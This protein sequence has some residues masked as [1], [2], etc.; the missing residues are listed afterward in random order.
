MSAIGGPVLEWYTKLAKP[1]LEKW[2]PERLPGLDEE[3]Q[4]LE[5]L[6]KAWTRRFQVCFLGNSGVGKSTLINALVDD[7]MPVLPQGGVG[8]LTALATRVGHSAEPYF[9]ATYHTGQKLNRIL[10]ILERQ[11]DLEAGAKGIVEPEVS[12]ADVPLD[13]EDRVE[14]LS[15]VPEPTDPAAD[16]LLTKIEAYKRVASLLIGGTQFDAHSRNLLF[17]TTGLRRALGLP[18]RAEVTFEPAEEARL[19]GL[20]AALER[21]KKGETVRVALDRNQAA[22]FQRLQEHAAGFLAPLI[23][24]IQVGWTGEVLEA[25]LQLVDLPGLGVA[26]DEYRQVTLREIREAKAVVLVVDRSGVTEASADLLRTTGFLNSLL[27]DTGNEDAEPVVLVVAVVKLDLTADDEKKQAKL[28][29]KEPHRRWL[30]YFDDVCHRAESLI[31]GQVRDELQKIL[32]T[33]SQTHRDEKEA[34]TERILSNLRIVP[35]SA[36]EHVRYYAGDDDD[37]ARIT[38]PAQSRIPAFRS[39]LAEAANSRNQRIASALSSHARSLASRITRGVEVIKEQWEETD[40]ADSEGERLREELD[41]FLAPRRKRMA[42]TR[43][44][45]REFLR[46]TMKEKIRTAV[47]EATNEARKDIGKYL[48]SLRKY[49][50]STL[51]AA[52]RRGG[53]FDGARTVDLPGE[54][55]LKFEE[56]LAIVWSKELLAPLRKRTS[57]LGE[58]YSRAVEE[59]ARWAQDQGARVNAKLIEALS[60]EVKEQTRQFSTVGRELVNELREKVKVELAEAIE[61]RVRKRCLKFVEDKQAEGPGVLSRMLTFFAGD[62]TDVVVDAAAKVAMRVLERNYSEVEA[63]IQE[64]LKQH[65]DPLEEAA[66]QIVER[67]EDSV[68]RRDRKVRKEVLEAAASVLEMA[69]VFEGEA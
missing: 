63:E 64:L 54:F 41:E 47:L 22:F 27:H 39:M 28:L 50:W 37:R 69:P 9:E 14:A 21:A 53:Y 5:R 57:E 65:P 10:F 30:D 7:R 34:M 17:L 31:R 45:Y 58:D 48:S 23:R 56:P 35:V 24:T 1:F 11:M 38:S 52:V 6:E 3:T 4:R 67:H 8:P 66:A 55:T 42:A 36:L 32:E 68:R 44:Q 46:E 49:N 20:R 62:L 59:V 16:S 12:L 43:A 18:P 40:R 25:G 15:V 29:G 51:R 26:N 33:G 60:A 19:A 61:D 13:E 2:S